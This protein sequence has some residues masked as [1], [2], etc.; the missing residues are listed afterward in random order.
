MCCVVCFTF[1]VLHLPR[2]VSLCKLSCKEGHIGPTYESLQ[3][4]F[5]L[6]AFRPAVNLSNPTIANISF[7][8]YAVLG[9]VSS[10]V[11]NKFQTNSN[12]N[13]I[14]SCFLYSRM[15]KL[16]SSLHSC[17]CDWWWQRLTFITAFW[18]CIFNL[19][20]LISVLAPRIPGLG[21][22]WMWRRLQDFSSSTEPLVSRYHRIWVVSCFT[23]L[24]RLKWIVSYFKC[25]FKHLHTWPNVLFF[26]F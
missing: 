12:L 11:S 25:L 13:Q 6:Q 5:D 23:T 26:L 18:G 22:G 20:V 14:T 2:S 8:L 15:R 16:R 9:V 10:H 17:G 21:S 24:K 3:A 19:F 7:T 4:V 1:W